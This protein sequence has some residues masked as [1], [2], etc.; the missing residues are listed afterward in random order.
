[1]RAGQVRRTV[2]GVAAFALALA[3]TGGAVIGGL[4]R[5]GVGRS[6][7]LLDQIDRLQR[8]VELLAGRPSGD[9]DVA[10]VGD[11]HLLRAGGLPLPSQ[12]ERALWKR[13]GD[14]AVWRVA[15]PGL[16]VFGQYCLSDRIA[17]TQPDRVVVEL[18]LADFS[19]AW[20]ET[21]EAALAGLVPP[22]RWLEALG[23]PLS[24][25][26]V[27]VDQL[28]FYGALVQSGGLAAWRRLRDEQ[29]RAPLALRGL[30]AQL[31]EHSPWPAGLGY[32]RAHDLAGLHR[33]RLGSERRASTAWVRTVLGPAL[34]GVGPR[35]P[36]L[37]FLDALL[38]HYA[39]AGVRA[40]VFVNPVNVQHLE[41]LGLETRGL[42]A[43]VARVRDVALRRGADFL[44]LHA[45][46]PDAAFHDEMDHLE[47]GGPGGAR[48]GEAIA[49]ALLGPSAPRQPHP[50]SGS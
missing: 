46:L 41:R 21:G 40:L 39:E 11:S 48:A 23:L 4:E 17:A 30:A 33:A 42:A 35:H 44:D 16:S 5:A 18:N 27:S 8:S 9:W 29:A 49:D 14:A 22:R 38:A 15:A 28:L 50:R 20:R 13:R 25:A 47:A 37:R 32:E 43:S 34:D 45:L 31:Q 19:L 2:A 1:M 24:H 26:G 6:T 10:V 12:L 7:T 36:S 3:A